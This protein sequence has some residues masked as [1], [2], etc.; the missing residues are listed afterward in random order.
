MATK[1]KNEK[2]QTNSDEQILTILQDLFILEALKSGA[3]VGDIRDHLKITKSRVSDISMLLKW[4][5][6]FVAQKKLR[7]HKNCVITCYRLI[8]IFKKKWTPKFL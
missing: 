5:K 2:K 4:R 8:T 3:Q 7:I 6:K 1:V